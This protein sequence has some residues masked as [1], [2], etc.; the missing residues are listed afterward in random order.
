[1]SLACLVVLAFYADATSRFGWLTLGWPSNDRLS[2]LAA[3][4]AGYLVIGIPIAP[5]AFREIR[6][7][8][9]RQ[10][11]GNTAVAWLVWPATAFHLLLRPQ[12]AEVIEFPRRQDAA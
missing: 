2:E 12:L 5:I 11:W 4:F 3:W 10:R 9:W 1:M 6:W 8:A 7:M